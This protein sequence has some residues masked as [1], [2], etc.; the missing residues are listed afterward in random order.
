MLKL[1]NDDLHRLFT[2]IKDMKAFQE[3]LE[4]LNNKLNDDVFDDVIVYELDSHESNSCGTLGDDNQLPVGFRANW[5]KFG[6]LK[7]WVLE[8]YTL[9]IFLPWMVSKFQT[10]DANFEREEI[11]DISKI[12]F[13]QLKQYFRSVFHPFFILSNSFSHS[14]EL[15]RNLIDE[16]MLHF[17]ADFPHMKKNKV[18]LFQFLLHY[19][20]EQNPIAS[21]ECYQECYP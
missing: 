20:G 9:P 1:N 15:P 6:Q 4:N 5:R 3:A 10:K 12:F 7:P 2:S 19:N 11:L 17:V 18:T 8:E 21:T 16:I 14:Y 13:M